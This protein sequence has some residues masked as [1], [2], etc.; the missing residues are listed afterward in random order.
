MKITKINSKT[1]C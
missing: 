1:D